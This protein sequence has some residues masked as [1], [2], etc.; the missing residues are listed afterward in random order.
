MRSCEF[1]D[2][3]VMPELY[4]RTLAVAEHER[5]S[6]LQHGLVGGLKGSFFV[7]AEILTSGSG[8]FV[9][10]GEEPAHLSG[11]DLLRPGSRCHR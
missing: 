3:D 10:V 9:S 4:A 5:Q 1:D 11:I 7:D 8:F 2:S 6:A